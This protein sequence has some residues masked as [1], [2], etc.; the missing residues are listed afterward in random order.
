MEK[1]DYNNRNH[2]EGPRLVGLILVPTGV[3]VL[4]SPRFLK[5]GSLEETILIVGVAC[6]VVGA[7][8]ISSYQGVQMNFEKKTVRSYSSFCGLRFGSWESLPELAE[9]RLIE[10]HQKGSNTPNGIS[11]TLH[12]SWVSY[13]LFVYA[14]PDEKA[15]FIF[16]YKKKKKAELNAQ[17]LKDRLSIPLKQVWF[18]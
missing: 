18:N 9:L 2:F 3:L 17:L 1:F 12:G 15:L 11:P 14:N 16:D 13:K 10:V 4:L 8:I 7:L 5:S 6:M